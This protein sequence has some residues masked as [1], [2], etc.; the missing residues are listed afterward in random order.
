MFTLMAAL[1]VSLVAIVVVELNWRKERKTY[2]QELYSLG[3]G[4][5]CQEIFNHGGIVFS[6]QNLSGNGLITA[7]KIND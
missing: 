2:E 4:K 6:Q 3:L 1:I 7:Q 5:Q